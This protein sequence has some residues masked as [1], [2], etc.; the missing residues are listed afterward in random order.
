[1]S[2]E[3]TIPWYE[4]Y[5]GADYLLIDTHTRTVDE[6]TFLCDVLDL[7]AGTSILD[8]GCGYGRHLVPLAM[9]GVDV[10]GCDLSGFMLSEAV[11]HIENESTDR[12]RSA[13]RLR[14][15]AQNGLRLVQCD[16]RELPFHSSFDC[17]CNLFN[18][19]G[20]FEEERDNFLM[21]TEIAAALKPGGL[22]LLEHVNRDFVLQMHTR[23]DWFEHNSAY[24]L[25]KKWFDPVRNRSEIDV[26]VID[27]A[28]A[29]HYHHSIR[30]Y[31]NTEITLLLEAAGF[32]VIE[33][34]GGFGG[35]EFDLST[36]KMIVLAQ[37]L[38]EVT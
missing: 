32:R 12:S 18:S 13:N 7:Q 15:W 8:V 25:E 36:D 14:K 31:T 3:Y 24:I 27:K 30:L 9:R 29:R 28:G 21:L 10:V 37:A 35:E 17:A 16:N 38:P 26:T 22:F 5:F 19:F 2:Q 34:F 23:K 20:Y 33:I 4:E 1:M 6:V 11:S